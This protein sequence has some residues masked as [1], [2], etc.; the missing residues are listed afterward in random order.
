MAETTQHI[1][2]FD[3]TTYKYLTVV[4]MSEVPTNGTTVPPIV[5][6]NNKEII[7]EN[8]VW[9]PTAKTWSGSNQEVVSANNNQQVNQNIS[10]LQANIKNLGNTISSM[11]TTLDTLTSLFLTDD[12]DSN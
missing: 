3:P 4:E 10:D 11:Q 2:L 6:V 12:T 8:P 1:Y 9:N 5:T 7:L